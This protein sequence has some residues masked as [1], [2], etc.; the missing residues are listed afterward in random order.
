MNEPI[1]CRCL[2][3]A[4]IYETWT[5]HA[6]TCPVEVAAREERQAEFKE[7]AEK[8]DLPE[9]IKQTLRELD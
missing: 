8:S 4:A 6:P 3:P 2:W 7:I 1:I 9:G 5:E